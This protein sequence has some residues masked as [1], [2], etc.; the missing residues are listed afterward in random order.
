MPPTTVCEV[1]KRVVKQYPNKPALRVKREGRWLTWTWRDYYR[2][3][4]AAAKSMVRVGVEPLRGVCV[5]G[6]NAPEW[7]ISYIGGIMVCGTYMYVCIT[8]VMFAGGG[9]WVWHL[10]HE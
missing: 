6:F 7:F 10:H 9:S 4:A 3:I 1:L 2:D 5:L 8:Y